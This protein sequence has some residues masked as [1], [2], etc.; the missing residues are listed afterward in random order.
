M[1]VMMTTE[2]ATAPP[3]PAMVAGAEFGVVVNRGEFPWRLLDGLERIGTGRL[4][5]LLWKLLG[6]ADDSRREWRRIA[7]HEC[8][9]VIWDELRERGCRGL[10]GGKG[11]FGAVSDAY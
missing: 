1:A 8:A 4:R 11:G 5:F 6:A 10:D 7:C 9:L 2:T 3:E